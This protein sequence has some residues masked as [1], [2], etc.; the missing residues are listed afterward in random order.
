MLALIMGHFNPWFGRLPFQLEN[1]LWG[2]VILVALPNTIW[3]VRY[4]KD[5]GA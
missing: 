5:R 1:A 3:Q 2:I 4:R